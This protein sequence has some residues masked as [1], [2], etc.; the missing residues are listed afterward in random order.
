[1]ES[2]TWHVPYQTVVYQITQ[3]Q[4]HVEGM[5]MCLSEHLKKRSSQTKE[6]LFFSVCKVMTNTHGATTETLGVWEKL[7]C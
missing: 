1:M 6:R 7:L 5:S 2:G 3:L 4:V